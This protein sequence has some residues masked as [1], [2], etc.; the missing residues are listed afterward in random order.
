MHFEN[1]VCTV[2][3]QGEIYSQVGS[4][5]EF[6]QDYQDPQACTAKTIADLKVRDLWL[7]KFANCDQEAILKLQTKDF[8]TGI[9]ICKFT[10]DNQL[11]ESCIKGKVT[12][13][14]IPKQ[15]QR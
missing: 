5:R 12:W 11:C 4:K 6:E 8:I 14:S 13:S 7:R 3:L 2:F 1:N 15:N 9:N 10:N